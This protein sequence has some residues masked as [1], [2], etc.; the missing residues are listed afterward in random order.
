[1][2]K[3]KTNMNKKLGI[4]LLLLLALV[5]TTGTFAYWASA[6]NG[7][8]NEQAVGTITIGS[9][10]AVSTEFVLTG[11][12]DTG[13]NLVPAAQL[14]NSPTGS[15]ASVAVSYDIAWNEVIDP[16]DDVTQLNGTSSTAPI[17]VT[18]VVTLVDSNN[19]TVTDPSVLALIVVTPDGGNATSLTLGAT[20]STFGFT[21]TMN[22]PAD[23]AEYNLI[24]SGTVTVTFT[25]E[26]GA[27]TTTDTN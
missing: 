18:P 10:N 4:A 24:A 3:E 6:V 19:N 7:P 9:G 2:D 27:V 25:F 26:L 5:T 23:Q 22:E 13:G 11:S 20:A 15:V 1:M 17:K 8:A 12:P 21:I 14:V 16:V